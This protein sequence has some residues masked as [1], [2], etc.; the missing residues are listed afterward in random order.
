MMVKI[1]SSKNR[2]KNFCTRISRGAFSFSLISLIF[3]LSS[4]FSPYLAQSKENNTLIDLLPYSESQEEKDKQRDALYRSLLTKS[5]HDKNKNEIEV[6]Y[7]SV[8]ATNQKKKPH[9]MPESPPQIVDKVNN[10]EKNPSHPKNPS[11]P[12]D[13][14]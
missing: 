12:K 4:I 2:C 7:K 14:N 6:R 1:Y 11:R 10:V 5:I 13:S 9:E 3:L 8:L